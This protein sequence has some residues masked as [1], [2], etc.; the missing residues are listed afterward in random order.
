[1]IASLRLHVPLSVTMGVCVCVW[2]GGCV[3]VAFLVPF[4]L[5]RVGDWGRPGDAGQTL[6]LSTGKISQYGTETE[7]YGWPDMCLVGRYE[8]CVQVP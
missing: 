5:S 8:L 3:S 4:P 7:S 1:M 6:V 2:V